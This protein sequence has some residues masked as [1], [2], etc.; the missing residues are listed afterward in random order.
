MAEPTPTADSANA[1]AGHLCVH[2]EGAH[3]AELPF[4]FE[5]R[6]SRV[7]GALAGSIASHA[8]LIFAILFLIRYTPTATTVAAVLPDKPDN[9]IV[10]LN[11]PGPGG[12][13]GG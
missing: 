13:G 8:A 5:Q 7:G 11:Q 1:S 6:Q 4:M 10:W 3:P 9:N 12:G 2:F